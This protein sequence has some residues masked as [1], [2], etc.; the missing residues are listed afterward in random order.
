MSDTTRKCH[1]YNTTY[2]KFGFI[3]SPSNMQPL[4]CLLCNKVDKFL[5]AQSV[6][7]LFAGS[8]KKFDDDLIASYNVSKLIVKSGKPHTIGKELIFPAL[9]EILK[10]VLH[11]T[12]SYRLH[13]KFSLSND[14]VRRRI[15]KMVEDVENSLCELLVTTEFSLH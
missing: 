3:P 2:L 1:Q 5:K 6:S 4:M 10:T 7:G 8:P 12:A 13:T 11:H 14:T 9:K 15:E